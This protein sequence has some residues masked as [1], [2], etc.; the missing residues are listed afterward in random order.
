MTLQMQTPL[1]HTCQCVCYEIYN[2]FQDRYLSHFKENVN[3]VV[4]QF[5]CFNVIYGQKTLT[6]AKLG[7][8]MKINSAA[9]K[10]Q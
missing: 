3:I 1:M 4:Q 2:A 6:I 8:W 9:S 7:Q 10:L 5:L